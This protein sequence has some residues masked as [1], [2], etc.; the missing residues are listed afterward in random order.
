M[1]SGGEFP[2]ERVQRD[3]ITRLLPLFRQQDGI[4]F[5]QEKVC[6]PRS[7]IRDVLHLAHDTKVSG[8]FAF[9]KT[10][11]RLDGYHWKNKTRDVKLYCKG[12][13]KC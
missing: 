8:H 7:L 10:L 6:V 2:E 11:S 12:F 9:S 4:L 13:L 1:P 3:K 5:Y